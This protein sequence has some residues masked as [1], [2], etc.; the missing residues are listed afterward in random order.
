MADKDRVKGE[1]GHPEGTNKEG[2]G[3][4]KGDDKRHADAA[5]TA[6]KGSASGAK[7]KAHDTKES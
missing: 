2:V 6:D 7:D 1:A 5:K 4:L 3:S